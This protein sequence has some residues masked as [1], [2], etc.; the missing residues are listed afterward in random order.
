[1]VAMGDLC[2]NLQEGVKTWVACSWHPLRMLP[3]HRMAEKS[4]VNNKP[5]KVCCELLGIDPCH[6]GQALSWKWDAC[7][8]LKMIKVAV[9]DCYHTRFWYVFKELHTNLKWLCIYICTYQFI[10][11]GVFQAAEAPP[12]VCHLAVKLPEIIPFTNTFCWIILY[13]IPSFQVWKNPLVF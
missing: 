3:E 1:M 4:D 6:V 5:L 12:Q 2:Q 9:R 10:P 8:I 11:Y 7:W 13:S